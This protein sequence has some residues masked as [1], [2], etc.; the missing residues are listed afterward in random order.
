MNSNFKDTTDSPSFLLTSDGGGVS[1]P[2]P[3]VDGP[4]G[5]GPGDGEVVLGIRPTAPAGRGRRVPALGHDELDRPGVLHHFAEHLNLRVKI[6]GFSDTCSYYL[7]LYTNYRRIKE[8]ETDTVESWPR[9]HQLPDATMIVLSLVSIVTIRIINNTH[10][11]VIAHVLEAPV[12]HL[13]DHITGFDPTVQR[14]GAALH[15]GSHVDSAV[16]SVS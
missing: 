8:D 11:F 3:G 5:L 7:L 6:Q 13:Q 4:D 14:H 12:V 1:H 9:S 16:S 10:R 15:D 2:R